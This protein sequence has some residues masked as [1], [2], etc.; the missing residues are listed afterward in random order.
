M[1]CQLRATSVSFLNVGESLFTFYIKNNLFELALLS[2]CT[3]VNAGRQGINPLKISPRRLPK[4]MNFVSDG[5]EVQRTLFHRRYCAQSW[6]KL[7]YIFTFW[8]HF[9]SRLMTLSSILLNAECEGINSLQ[10]SPCRLPARTNFAFDWRKIQRTV[11][12]L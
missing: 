12:F 7:C 8:K 3:F 11:R 2:L 6:I 9:L 10:F 1:N 4:R 5:R